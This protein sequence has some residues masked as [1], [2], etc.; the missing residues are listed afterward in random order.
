MSG[1]VARRLTGIERSATV[2]MMETVQALR[3][4]GT[5]IVDLSGGEPDFATADHISGEASA[6][7]LGGF[8]HY[9]SS[10]GLPEL[11]AAIAEKLA[12]DN[13]IV[14]DPATDVIVT[15]S[16]KHA[17]FIC[18]MALLDPGDEVIVPTPAWVSYAAMASLAGARSVPAE[19]SAD[20]GFRL[21]A[22]VL[23]AA[24]TERTKVLLLNNPG[25]PTGRALDAAELDVVAEFATNHELVIIADE[26]Y[27][28]VR[29]DGRR[30]LSV[31]ALPACA[32]RTLT[33]NGFSKGYAMTGWRLGWVAGPADL[34]SAALKVQEHTVSCAASFAQRGGVAA[35][36]GSQDVVTDM[37]EQYSSRRALLVKGLNAL[38]GVT[39]ALPEGAFY[40]F[41]DIRGTGFSK[42][43]DFAQWLLEE[44]A[45]AVTPGTAFGPG[46]EGHVRLSFAT[47]EAVLT[48]ALDRI[49]AAL[50]R[51]A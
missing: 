22:E 29:Y 16:A 27:E 14:V 37:V 11:R 43:A 48:E 21:T 9:T 7:L 13:G 15:P 4:N 42:S 17:L 26:I 1:K 24:V 33:V 28:K 38:P 51:R 40:A 5:S 23:E 34:V 32:D 3:A 18:L 10:R 20:N 25:N 46:G 35:L 8:T 2:A 45:V 19:L 30:H 12:T 41:P 49:G 6:A 31:A 50:A 36:Q 44:V 47:S 39:C